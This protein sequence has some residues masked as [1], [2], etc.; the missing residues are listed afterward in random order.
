M[1]DDNEYSPLLSPP[2]EEKTIPKDRCF[3]V[4]IIF[5]LLGIGTLLPW[6][7]FTNAKSYFMYKLRNTT[8]NET[9][10]TD[11]PSEYNSMQANFESYLAIAAMVPNVL[12]MF[13]NTAATKLIAVHVR[14]IIATITMILMFVVTIVLAKVD[15]DTWQSQFLAITM[16][17]VVITN[18]GSAVMQGG[19]FGLASMFPKEYT[20]AVMGGM[21]MGGV[22]A[23]STNILCISLGT[24][25]LET[26]FGYFM[27]AEIVIIFA[28]I[29]YFCLP[30]LEY[31]THHIALRT[32]PSGSCNTA[33]TDVAPVTRSKSKSAEL[34]PVFKQI[35]MPAICV[36]VVFAVTLSCY[37]A[38]NSA[39]T[40]INKDAKDAGSWAKTYFVPVSCFLLF[41]V[42]DLLGRTVAGFCQWPRQKSA[43]LPVLSLLRVV[44]IP[45]FLLCN[46]RPR[47]HLPYLIHNDYVPLVSMV[48]FA[49]SNGYLGTLCMMYGPS[50]VALDRMETAGGMMS[51]FLALGLGSGSLTSLLLVRLV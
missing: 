44:F 46:V 51:F 43:L 32:P 10:W 14:I 11:R 12:F 36:F 25:A 28:L 30:C 34:V 26:G 48:V 37:P 16:G 38:V 19:L 24:G 35:W 3:L 45:V 5:Y 49:F 23:S 17:T 20:Q 6:N 33:D 31:A 7:F 13:L 27:T 42:G 2:K 22:I 9:T 47:H 29:G 21:G 4:Y 8:M 40:S 39:I 15:T 18:A 41:N 50:M 1:E